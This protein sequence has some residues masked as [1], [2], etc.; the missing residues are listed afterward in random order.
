MAR[1]R[2]TTCS[3]WISTSVTYAREF[4]REKV[5][6]SV[7]SVEDGSVKI[8]AGTMTLKHAKAAVDSYFLPSTEKVKLKIKIK[9]KIRRKIR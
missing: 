4:E 2:K 6:L 3:R 8:T 7:V 5:S 1:S 9:I